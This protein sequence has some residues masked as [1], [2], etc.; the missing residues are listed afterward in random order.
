MVEKYPKSR[1][2]L[3]K[4]SDLGKIPDLINLEITE[5]IVEKVACRLHGSA[6]LCGTAV[7]CFFLGRIVV[8]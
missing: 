3:T 4:L 7:Y 8:G 2:V 5:K 1:A 6:G